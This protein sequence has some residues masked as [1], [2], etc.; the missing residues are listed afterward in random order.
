MRGKV[1]LTELQDEA[2]VIASKV[3]EHPLRSRVRVLV[4]QKPD[5]NLAGESPCAGMRGPTQ[6]PGILEQAAGQDCEFGP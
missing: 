1:D 2:R 3:R 5:P 6:L 4:G